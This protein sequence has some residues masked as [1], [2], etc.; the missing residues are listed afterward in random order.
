MGPRHAE[1]DPRLAFWVG[2][3]RGVRRSSQAPLQAHTVKMR[4]RFEVLDREPPRSS[5]LWLPAMLVLTLAVLGLGW[6]ADERTRTH[7]SAAVARCE[8][9]LR[10]ASALSEWRLG[11]LTNYLQPALRT[12]HGVQDLHLADLMAVRASHVLLGAQRADRACRTVSVQP[13]HVSLVDRRN[14]AVAYSGA[15]V[16]LLQTVAAQGPT[17][18]RDDS[19]LGRL[20]TQ[21]GAD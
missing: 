9:Q 16:T 3:T 19:L 7:E 17:Q 14:A 21:A 18:F 15:L 13:W 6:H 8:R 2:Q 12:T 11:I 1:L 5:R 20:R 10:N 4:E